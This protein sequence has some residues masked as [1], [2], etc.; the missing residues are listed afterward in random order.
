MLGVRRKGGARRNS[1]WV[2]NSLPGSGPWQ[3]VFVEKLH[4]YSHFTT[5][6]LFLGVVSIGGDKW[7]VSFGR[8]VAAPPPSNLSY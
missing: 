7:P 4:L 1:Y 5:V 3:K 8:L 6:F 2:R